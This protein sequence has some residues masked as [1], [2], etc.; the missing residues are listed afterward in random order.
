[1]DRDQDD[2][3]RGRIN[4]KRDEL[5]KMARGVGDDDDAQEHQGVTEPVNLD[6]EAKFRQIHRAAQTLFLIEVDL[7]RRWD[8]YTDTLSRLAR[9]EATYIEMMYC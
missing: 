6:P 5:G 9:D 4:P 2:G 8:T 7:R 1:M 3:V